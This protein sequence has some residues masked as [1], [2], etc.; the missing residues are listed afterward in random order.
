MTSLPPLCV[1]PSSSL[2]RHLPM[3]YSFKDIS[4][5]Y[6]KYHPNRQYFHAGKSLCFDLGHHLYVS[7]LLTGWDQLAKP[8]VQYFLYL[9]INWKNLLSHNNKFQYYHKPW[10][11]WMFLCLIIAITSIK[12]NLYGLNELANQRRAHNVSIFTS[13][14]LWRPSIAG[15]HNKQLF[16]R[17]ETGILE[18]TFAEINRHHVAEGW[19]KQQ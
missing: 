16:F 15:R 17:N 2:Y 3:P 4:Q 19:Q 13:A 10:Y 14:C 5:K 8:E 12:H 9:E 7:S 18:V 6:R 1:H 11:I